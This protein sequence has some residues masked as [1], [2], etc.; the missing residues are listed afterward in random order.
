M[1]GLLE[2]PPRGRLF[3]GTKEERQLPQK[4]PV[5][6][7]N[8][9]LFLILVQFHVGPDTTSW[10]SAQPI[11]PRHSSGPATCL[12]AGRT[13]SDGDPLACSLNACTGL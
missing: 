8:E 1:L 3:Q 12:V 6:T 4:N 9:G 5:L 11:R 7:R 2:Q 13:S 10:H